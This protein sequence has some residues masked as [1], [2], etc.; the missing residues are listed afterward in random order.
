MAAIAV[1]TLASRGVEHAQRGAERNEHEGE[2]AG[3]GQDRAGAQRVGTPHAGDAKQ[4][5]D[6]RGLQHR[7]GDGGGEDEPE[8]LAHHRH[9]DGHADAHEEQRQQQAAERLDVG[10]EFMPVVR[11]GEQ[12]AGQERAERHRHAGLLHQQ[13]GAQHHQQRRGGHHLARAGLRQQ[14]EERIEQIAAGDDDHRDGADDPRHGAQAVHEPG[15]RALAALRQQRQR[16]EQRHDRHVLEQQDGEGALAVDL[17]E[18]A[19]LFE[20]LQGDRGRRHGERDPRD[21]GAAPVEQSAEYAVPPMTRV[22]MASWAAPRPKMSR[23]ISSSRPIS[24]SSPMTKSS[25]TTPSSDTGT[26]L[27]GVLKAARPYGPITIPATR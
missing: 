18:L 3:R 23:R 5:P 25:S 19:A 17:L 7:H 21:R 11:L 9:V 13:R 16:G 14:P 8:I 6:D 2:L 24:S 12:H 27:S 10:L 20:N 26:M 4:Q 1:T 22:V 15:R